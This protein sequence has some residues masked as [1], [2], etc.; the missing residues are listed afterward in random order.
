MKHTKV[1]LAMCGSISGTDPLLR[2]YFTCYF[3]LQYL[4]IWT[5]SYVQHSAQLNKQTNLSPTYI[6]R[7]IKTNVGFYGYTKSDFSLV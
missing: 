5:S 7:F 2:F 1:S 6:Y 4:C 3:A